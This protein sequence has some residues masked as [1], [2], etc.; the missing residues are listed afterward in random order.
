MTTIAPET[1]TDEEVIEVPEESDDPD[2]AAH[3]VYVPSKLVG[4][5]VQS[6]LLQAR[7]EGTEVAAICGYT[8][9]PRRSVEGLPICEECKTLYDEHL[10][11]DLPSGD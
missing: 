10:G 8:W 5:D 4:M 7:V 9:V 1:P 6:Y 3:I 11:G 2:N